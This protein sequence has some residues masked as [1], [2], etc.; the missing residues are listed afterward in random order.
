MRDDQA[1]GGYEP[2]SDAIMTVRQREVLLTGGNAAWA[3]PRAV[4]HPCDG[5]APGMLARRSLHR[6]LARCRLWGGKAHKVRF[7][8]GAD[9]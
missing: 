1:D 3:Q 2:G 5:T 6:M 4:P 9:S 7:P 8:S